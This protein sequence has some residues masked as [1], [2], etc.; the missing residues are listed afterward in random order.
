MSNPAPRVSS[1][2]SSSSDAWLAISIEMRQA[3]D[4][5][6]S[7][8]QGVDQAHRIRPARNG[9][10]HAFVRAQHAISRNR[11][12]QAVEYGQSL[13]RKIDPGMAQYMNRSG[14]RV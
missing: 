14:S 11:L 8:A 5:H 12:E 9:R 2:S 10:D 6:A 4:T 7:F 1:F 13:H 3:H